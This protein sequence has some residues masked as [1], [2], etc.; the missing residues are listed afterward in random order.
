MSYTIFITE[1]QFSTESKVL[2]HLIEGNS[3]SQLLSNY[4]ALLKSRP[5]MP[6]DSDIVLY[7]DDRP[8]DLELGSSFVGDHFLNT[9][10][11]VSKLISL[12]NGTLPMSNFKIN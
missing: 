9:N 2:H 12:E 4:D 10:S 3:I 7:E 11:T 6:S 1:M 5:C 8:V